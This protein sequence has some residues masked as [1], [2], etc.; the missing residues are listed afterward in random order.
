MAPELLGVA[1]HQQQAAGGQRQFDSLEIFAKAVP[2]HEIAR[3]AQAQ[4]SDGGP[5]AEFA[6][7]V[8]VHAHAVVFITIV[9]E[10]DAVELQTGQGFDP[11]F[12]LPQD[13]RPRQRFEANTRIAIG[14]IVYYL[15][16]Q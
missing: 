11:G 1:L 16:A 2:Q 15:C 8:A 5:M 3:L 10:Q 7:V 13:W 14:H 6:F 4:R 12:D 9:V